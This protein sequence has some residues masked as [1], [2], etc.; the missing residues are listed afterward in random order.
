MHE[1]TGRNFHS[2]SL[3]GSNINRSLNNNASKLTRTLQPDNAN[4]KL[5]IHHTN[6]V[7]PSNDTNNNNSTVRSK[8]NRWIFRSIFPFD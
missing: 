5:K 8:F 3:L 2:S 7:K 6:G 4:K 1:P